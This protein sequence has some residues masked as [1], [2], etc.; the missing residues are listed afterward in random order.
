MAEAFTWVG[1]PYVSNGSIKDV[2]VDCAM[3]LIEIFSR[4]GLIPWFDPRPYPA[5]WAIHQ[6]TELYLEAVLTWAGEVEGPPKPGDVVLFKFG[7]CWAHGGIVTEW[8]NLIHANP[9]GK[10]RSDSFVSNYNLAKRRPRF[11]SYWCPEGK[12]YVLPEFQTDAEEPV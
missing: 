8:P 5:Q 10:C 3:I 2:G 6:R 11:F 12:G 7:H 1:T 9:P 4:V